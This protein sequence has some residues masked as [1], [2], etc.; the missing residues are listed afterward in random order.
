MRPKSLALALALA[1]ALA[2]CRTRPF[3]LASGDGGV[4]VEDSGA[5]IDLTPRDGLA[6][7]LDLTALP[8]LSQLG[9][10]GL[11]ACV[12]T[13]SQGDNACAMGC[14]AQA[15]PRAQM[16]FQSDLMCGVSWCLGVNGAAAARC[17]ADASGNLVDAPNVPPGD[18]NVCLRN[19]FSS[20]FGTTCTPSDDPACMPTSCQ[21]Q[22]EVCSHN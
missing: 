12:G 9:C 1:A 18:C 22:F 11:A 8:D 20:L 15:T 4:P 17:A 14:F 3:E 6:P 19:V 10:A 13:C 2:A 5:P 16:M 21:N 7:T